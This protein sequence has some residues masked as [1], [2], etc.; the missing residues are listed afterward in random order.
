[1][2]KTL[3]TLSF[4]MITLIGF[5]QAKLEI[6]LKA[7]ANFANTDIDNSESIT[8]FHGGLYGLI[9]LANIGIQP[10]VLLSKQGSEFSG[11]SELDLSY[12]NVPVMLKFY[13][14][15]GLNIQAGPQFGI[16][17]NAEDEDGVDLKSGLKKL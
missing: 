9:K 5:S 2:K 10:E 7:G 16:L 11:G 4:T 3:L 8:S 6:G 14:P 12:I 13:L 17:T 1:M 15:A